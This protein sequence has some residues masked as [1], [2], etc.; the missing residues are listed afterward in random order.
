MA[1]ND[2]GLSARTRFIY[3][4]TLPRGCGYT[5]WAY[6]LHTCY[7]GHAKNKHLL[8]CLILRRQ[9][10]SDMDIVLLKGHKIEFWN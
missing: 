5:W 2:Y 10:S 3:G 4:T 9:F 8:N 6:M 1:A 7:N